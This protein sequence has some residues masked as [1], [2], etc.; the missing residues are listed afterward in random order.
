MRLLDRYILREF[1]IPFGYC[2][3]GFL[4]FWMSF[5]LFQDLPELQRDHLHFLDYIEYYL[6]KV[7]ELLIIVLPVAMLL[8]LLYALS[9]HARYHELTAMRSAGISLWR[10]SLPYLLVGF[11]AS[12]W[13]FALSEVWGAAKRGCGRGDPQAASARG[14]GDG[15]PGSKELRLPLAAWADLADGQL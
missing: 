12:L 7:P 1:L 11:V 3:A 4:I 9:S 10:I 2:L 5:D 6:W 15:K 8:A 14:H 13:L